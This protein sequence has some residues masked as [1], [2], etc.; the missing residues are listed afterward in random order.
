[1]A[2]QKSTG[3]RMAIWGA[4]RKGIEF[5]TK[6]DKDC[7]YIG[8]VFDKDENKYGKK[9][10]TGHRVVDYRE[11]EADI[12]ILSSGAFYWETRH[13]LSLL[14]WKSQLINL[15]DV[16]FGRLSFEELNHGVNL[17]KVRSSLVAAVVILYHPD[18]KTVENVLSYA[19]AVDQV[20]LY[21]N[22][23][24]SHEHLFRHLTQQLN[25]V[26]IFNGNNRGIGAAINETA[27]MAESEGADWLFTF[28]QDSKADAEMVPQMRKYIESIDYRDCIGIVAP[29]I[30]SPIDTRPDDSYIQE[31]PYIMYVSTVI[32]SGALHN[33]SAFKKVGGYDERLFIDYVDFDYCVRCRL[34]GFVIAKIPG[35]AIYHQEDSPFEVQEI[36]GSKR[37]MGKYSPQRYYYQCRNMLYCKE[38]Y[39]DTAPDFSAQCERGL[40]ILYKQIELDL[41]HEE[42]LLAVQRAEKD[43]LKLLEDTP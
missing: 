30:V 10:P 14:P 17:Q 25:C 32:Q 31:E 7:H 4:G 36:N 1:M 40:D 26:Y 39:R 8:F 18:V 35:A 19:N 12:V 29:R 16:F 38:R 21:D 41:N 34:A 20:Y 22:S 13:T 2:M 23:E 33:L 3:K 28:D 27:R 5:L 6:F 43:Y 24:T 9:L 15:D 42:N 37:F 11:N